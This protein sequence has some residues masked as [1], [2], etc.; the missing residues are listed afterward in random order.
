[1][2]VNA[3]AY[4]AFMLAKAFK[5]FGESRYWEVAEGNLEFVLSSQLDDGSWLYSMDGPDR[6]TDHF[7]T[8]FVMKALAKIHHLTGH[9]GCRQALERGV[10]YYFN[11]L[12]DKNC[13][14]IPFSRK[15]RLVVYRRELYDYAEC[16]NLGLLLKNLFGDFDRVVN[17]VIGDLLQRWQH[18]DGF[19]RTRQLLVGWNNVPMHRWGLSIVFRSLCLYLRD[20]SQAATASTS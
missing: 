11:S 13:L 20:N 8:C 4:R 7:H 18:P 3:S 15:P 2:V 14:P 17:S 9:A 1:M 5:D 12:L 19:F 6:F 16:L 10:R